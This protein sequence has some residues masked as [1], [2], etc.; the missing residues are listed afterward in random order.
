M[1]FSVITDNWQYLLF[2]AYPDG[3]L[4]G[5]ALTLIM[6][7]LAGAASIV[8]NQQQTPFCMLIIAFQLLTAVMTR[9]RI[10]LQRVRNAILAR[11]L[12]TRMTPSSHFETTY[13]KIRAGRHDSTLDIKR[14]HFE[15]LPLLRLH[16][17]KKRSS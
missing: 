14:R 8:E 3:P 15:L 1:D 7:V 10:W 4:E 6:S 2:G 9:W 17:R 5:A 13:V 16:N 12:P 11:V